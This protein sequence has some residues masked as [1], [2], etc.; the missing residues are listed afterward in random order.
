MIAG[1]VPMKLQGNGGEDMLIGGTTQY[2]TNTAA[3][4]AIMAEWTR[5]DESYR[6]RVQH[7]TRGGG[8]N[9]AYK[10]NAS[11]VTSNGG[12]NILQGGSLQD[13]FFA[14]PSLDTTD[15]DPASE[16]LIPL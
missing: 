8:L 4:N 10:L 3:L 15:I 12:G 5:T 6:L 9:G 16:T 13:L 2:D 7:I 1:S 14:K 11:T